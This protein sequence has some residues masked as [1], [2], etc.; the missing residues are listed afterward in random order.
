MKARVTFFLPVFLALLLADVVTTVR[1]QSALDGFDPNAQ[2][3][4]SLVA[5]ASAA[6]WEDSH[7]RGFQTI[8]GVPRN[9]PC[10]HKLRRNA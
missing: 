4:G 3:A 2:S 10:A 9:V 5:I 7:W 6:R 1:G 8:L